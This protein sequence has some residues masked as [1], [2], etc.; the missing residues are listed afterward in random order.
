MKKRI[1]CF[2]CSFTHYHWPTWADLLIVDALDQGFELGENWGKMGV[3]NQYIF[4]KIWEADAKHHFTEDDWIFVSWTAM[5]RD[6]RWYKGDWYHTKNREDLHP[7]FGPAEYMDP[8]NYTLRDSSL[9]VSTQLALKAIGVNQRHWTINNIF[10]APVTGGQG[11]PASQ[12][13]DTFD[14]AFDC[15]PLVTTLGENLDSDRV[16]IIVGDQWYAKPKPDGHPSTWEHW[17]YLVQNIANTDIPW[18][19][20]NPS[21]P[22]H[23][24]A[25][26]WREQLNPAKPVQLKQLGW[27]TPA[28]GW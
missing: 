12:V 5:A 25:A 2:G 22:A 10:D 28:L 1:F 17:N 14:L 6:D 15:P 27:I 9:I 7:M 16:K 21:S 19:R 4:N 23:K 24:M 13:L 18:L 3:G 20:A 26:E 11:T 8:V